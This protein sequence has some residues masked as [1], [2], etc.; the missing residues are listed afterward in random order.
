MLTLKTP[1]CFGSARARRLLINK[2]RTHRLVTYLLLVILWKCSCW[3]S[4]LALVCIN[5]FAQVKWIDWWNLSK[6]RL[7]LLWI[8]R[9]AYTTLEIWRVFQFAHLTNLMR[10][11]H[12]HL[13]AIKRNQFTLPSCVLFEIGCSVQISH[14]DTHFSSLIHRNCTAQSTRCLSL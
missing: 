9:R 13:I 10:L 8:L 7:L 5:Q 11:I 12:F 14:T 3:I 1:V 4:A 2:S 6:R